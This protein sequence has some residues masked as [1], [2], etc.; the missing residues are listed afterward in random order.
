MKHTCA[1]NLLKKAHNSCIYLKFA[2]NQEN[3]SYTIYFK[4]ITL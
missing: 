2:R 4:I 1:S 3:K